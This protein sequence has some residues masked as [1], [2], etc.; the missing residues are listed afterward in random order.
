VSGATWYFSSVLNTHQVTSIKQEAFPNR[1]LSV[2]VHV[3]GHNETSI[4]IR[5]Y[6]ILQ[7]HV[8]YNEKP[9]AWRVMLCLPQLVSIRIATLRIYSFSCAFENPRRAAFSFVTC[10][11]PSARNNSTPTERIFMT[12]VIWAFF[13]Y[14]S[15][16]YK[17]SYNLTR[18]TRALHEGVCAF[19]IISRWTLLAMKNVT[20]KRCRENQTTCSVFSDSFFSSQNRSVYEVMWR[21]VVQ[22][23]GPHIIL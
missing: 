5:W 20:D 2:P 1:R 18:I 6:L 4:T 16:K 14:L 11:R 17:F 12:F 22:P 9:V 10:V 19:V 13:G 23:D 8:P 3:S 21:N 15:R 7:V